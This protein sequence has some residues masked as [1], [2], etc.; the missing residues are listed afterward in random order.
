MLSFQ[1]F[2]GEQSI[3]S[4][5]GGTL[6]IVENA[7]HNTWKN[8]EEALAK[9]QIEVGKAI[10]G[11]NI[12]Q[13]KSVSMQDDK[14]KYLFCVSI[15]AGW[16]NPGSGKAY[17]LDLG[18][19]ITISNQTGLVVALHYMSKRCNKCE[20]GE[21]TGWQ[22]AHTKSLCACNY[23]SSSKGMEAHGALQSCLHHHQ[24]HNIVWDIIVMDDKTLT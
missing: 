14:G 1:Q 24:H 12:E 13:E 6:S 3:A 10:T 19:H 8:I 2:N 21:K 17:N 9:T 5:L 16:N 15:D 20:I 4:I 18:H 11:E 7:F 22:N 23:T